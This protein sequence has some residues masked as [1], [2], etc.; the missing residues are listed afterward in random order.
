MG[1]ARVADQ[2]YS[3]IAKLEGEIKDNLMLTKTVG[4]SRLLRLSAVG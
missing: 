3:S 4:P 2:K 1:L